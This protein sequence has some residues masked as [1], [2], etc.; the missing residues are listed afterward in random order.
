M[1]LP[2]RS[3]EPLYKSAPA[4]AFFVVEGIA[5]HAKT[6]R[7]MEAETEGD[8]T[9]QQARCGRIHYLHT[10]DNTSLCRTQPSLLPTKSEA[11]LTHF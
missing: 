7:G 9:D 8:I 3:F 1:P 4:L 5:W 11:I 2:F 10:I 6:I